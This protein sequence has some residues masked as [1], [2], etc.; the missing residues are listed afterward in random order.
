MRAR[1]LR[2]SVAGAL[3]LG[4]LAVA[5][6]GAY[7]YWQSYYVSRGFAPVRRVPNST[8][9]HNVLVRFHSEALGR[10]ADY[11]A[12]LPPH[13]DPAR[14]RYPVY[15]LLH[16]TP[17]RPQG[18][19]AIAHIGT[20]LDNLIALHRVH[21]MIM[22]FP[23]GRIGGSSFSD[24]EWANTPSGAYESYVA[25][26]VHD[27]DRRFATRPG[28]RHRVIAGFS[29]GAYGAIN[30]ALHRLALFGAVQVWSGYFVQHRAGV[31]AHADPA[32]L[33][34]NSPALYVRGLARP[35]RRFPLSVYMFVGR[36]DHAS[37]QIRA[38]D[39]AMLAVGIHAG[40]HIYAGGHDWQLWNTHVDAM[41][42]RA[43]KATAVHV[44]RRP[45]HRRVG[46]RRHRRHRRHG[47]RRRRRGLRATPRLAVY[48]FHRHA[49]DR[50]GTFTLLAGLLL[51]L[52][53]AAVINLGFLLQHQGLGE[54]AAPSLLHSF[55][56][57]LRN[58]AW[59]SGQALGWVGFVAQIVAV[60]IAPL[61]LV[62]AFAAGGLALSV[63]LA[64]GL[65]GQR[66]SRRQFAA[67]LLIAAGL[68]ILPVA[69]TAVHDRLAAGRL[70]VTA[71]IAGAA[72][73]A[74]ALARSGASRAVAAGIF[75]GAADAAIKA[76]SV[77]WRDHGASA[78][79]S[80]WTILAAVATF[81]GF[82]A[83]QAALREGGAVTSI[84]MMNAFAAL[85]ALS[86]GLVAFGESL[87]RNGAAVAAHVVAIV[88]VLACVPPLAAAQ[89]EIA[90]AG[91]RA[92]GSRD[93]SR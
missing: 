42:V 90:A 36:G 53:S 61:S 93:A 38:M 62:Q 76:V 57:A 45:R 41:L 59:L 17:G 85:V 49:R 1:T 12:Y 82:L 44:G 2:R 65:F 33:A 73:V 92:R 67:V 25:D 54:D 83:F 51:A 63:P 16:G 47:H 21:P 18:Y 3:L 19:Y 50:L 58:R 34:Y 13:Y 60:A 48:T 69:T 24:S 30:I 14:H 22:V 66:V 23:D 4:W 52:A 77:G 32:T 64:A 81:A 46:E 9:G 8:A 71:V 7:G 35:L 89:A 75:Y 5:A 55:R 87:G 28:R 78:L 86:C 37:R 70:A 72:A 27:V 43:S 88:L 56:A 68:A 91:E 15:Y 39:E 6:I 26:V 29:A 40:Y 11:Y 31:F 84:S 80:G 79:W 74:I 20:R 10:V